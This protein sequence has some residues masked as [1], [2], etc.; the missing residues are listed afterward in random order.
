MCSL[1]RI[2]TRKFEDPLVRKI[3][4]SI[5]LK[6]PLTPKYTLIKYLNYSENGTPI[7]NYLLLPSTQ[8]PQV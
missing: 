6:I 8:Q 2:Q 5:H 4:Q 3:M 1:I 7:T